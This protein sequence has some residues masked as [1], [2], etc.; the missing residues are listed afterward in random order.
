M[1]S[2]RW[3]HSILGILGV[4][5]VTVT[6][7]QTRQVFTLQS[8][9]MQ[10][11]EQ[12]EQPPA[13][14]LKTV[15]G[16]AVTDSEANLNREEKMELLQLRGEITRLRQRQRELAPIPTENQALLAR[17]AAAQAKEKPGALA[18]PP[19]YIQRKAARFAGYGTPDATLESLFWAIAN[20]DTNTIL[21]IMPH[22]TNQIYGTEAERFWREAGK[23]PGFRIL[24]KETQSDSGV[25][26]T[27]EM[28]PGEEVK[29]EAYGIGEDWQLH[30]F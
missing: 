19:G 18:L 12:T 9:A 6:L 17:I 22:L 23:L 5:S 25:S 1:N 2:R 20:R 14:V 30:G 24:N 28:L 16:H 10:L 15:N 13:E 26:L 27:I 11:R 3:I 8:E 7:L 21:H 29:I 4:A